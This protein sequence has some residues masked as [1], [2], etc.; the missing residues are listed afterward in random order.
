[1]EEKKKKRW[2]RHFY[3]PWPKASVPAEDPTPKY[4]NI[5]GTGDRRRILTITPTG[6]FISAS[7]YNLVDGTQ[8]N[9]PWLNTSLASGCAIV[10][11]F[12]DSYVI[13]EAKWYQSAADAMGTWKWQGSNDNSSYTD[14]GTSFALGGAATQTLTSLSVNTVSYRYYKL[15]GVSGNTSGNP[16][17][18]E[19]EFQISPRTT[20]VNGAY[21][22]NALGDGSRPSII[23]TSSL[24]IQTGS[25]SNLI[26][27][28]Y[29]NN[30]NYYPASSANQWIN[31]DFGSAK[32]I[33]ECAW[34]QS[35]MDTHGNW[36]WQG[37]NDNSNWTDIGGSFILGGGNNV[38]S[39]GIQIQ[40]EL[41]VNTVKYRYYRLLGISG[42]YSNGPSLLEAEFRI[43]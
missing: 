26:D 24:S 31:F 35:T 13:T 15:Q 2:T 30:F 10:F 21:Y 37:S 8:S 18:R 19:I 23:I 6:S 7:I 34:W 39:F 36:K 14:I 41:R 9:G 33:D 40:R 32:L 3:A 11:D 16:Y 4:T 12:G 5:G 17:L 38:G 20:S 22:D 28:L 1:M 27:G 25:V 29:S 43:S 42:S